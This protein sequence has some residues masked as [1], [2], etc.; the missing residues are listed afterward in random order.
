MMRLLG[1][2]LALAAIL[3]TG[4]KIEGI[5][6]YAVYIG[7]NEAI[8]AVVP[9]AY[10]SLKEKQAR[11]LQLAKEFSA[12]LDRP[13]VLTEDSLAFAAI[14]RIEKRGRSSDVRYL[15]KRLEKIRAS[16]YVS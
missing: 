10:P 6:N 9:E 13:V 8:V 7:E 11:L 2:A 16:C 3:P 14:R 4:A 5:K 1:A 12:Y 15:L